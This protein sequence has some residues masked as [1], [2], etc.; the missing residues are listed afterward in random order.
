MSQVYKKELENG[1]GAISCATYVNSSPNCC[2]KHY[3][4]V[5]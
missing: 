2:K 3:F 4:S 5:C 1:K